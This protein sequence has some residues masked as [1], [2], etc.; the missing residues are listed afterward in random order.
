MAPTAF[1]DVPVGA[2]REEVVAS[3]G[4]PFAV[5]RKSD[6]TTEYEYIEKLNIGA[7]NVSERHF[8]IIMKD[9]KVV[10]KRVQTEQARPYGFDSYDMQTTQ[11][12]GS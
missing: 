4:E 12:S 9:G 3:C 8:F 5:H 6:G 7:R 2:T 1:Y 11:Q 10:S